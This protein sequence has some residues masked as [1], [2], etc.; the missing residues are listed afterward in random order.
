MKLFV[1]Q[2]C[3]MMEKIL[4]LTEEYASCKIKGQS[5][6]SIF[7]EMI[8][9]LSEI[10]LQYNAIALNY[11]FICDTESELL[12]TDATMPE[13][14]DA[15]EYYLDI[16]SNKKSYKINTFADDVKLLNECLNLFE[17]VISNDNSTPIYMLKLESGSLFSKL[18]S[19][20]IQLS[21]FPSIVKNFAEAFHTFKMTGAEVAEKNQR[22]N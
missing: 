16:R 11:Q 12:E 9:K 18:K 15:E 5:T 4:D 7:F 3:E 2:L 20:N 1:D 13:D 6:V 8:D 19:L 22:L 17:L 10:Q 14:D 21:V